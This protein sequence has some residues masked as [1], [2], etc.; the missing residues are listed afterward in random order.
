MLRS[1]YEHKQLSSKFP[2]VPLRAIH[3]K[4]H[5]TSQVFHGGR[6][7]LG[8]IQDDFFTFILS[9]LNGDRIH[10]LSADLDMDLWVGANI[11]HPIAAFSP[12]GGDVVGIACWFVFYYLQHYMARQSAYPTGMSDLQGALS[13]QPSQMEFVEPDWSPE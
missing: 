8:V 5:E 4:P 6:M 2:E 11:F 9:E 3:L 13:E 10:I 12:G 7:A 1:E